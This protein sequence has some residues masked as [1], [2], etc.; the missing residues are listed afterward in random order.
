M[1]VLIYQFHAVIW[2]GVV[3]GEIIYFDAFAPSKSRAF[4]ELSVNVTIFVIG[5]ML[6]HYGTKAIARSLSDLTRSS[7]V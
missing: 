1:P 3:E 4:I 2:G 6:E 7:S 5:V